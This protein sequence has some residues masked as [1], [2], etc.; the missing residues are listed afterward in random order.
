MSTLIPLASAEMPSKGGR[1]KGRALSELE[2]EHMRVLLG[3]RQLARQYMHDYEERLEDFA[4]RMRE[5]GC[6]T[7][8]MADALEIGHST[9]QGWITNAL[10]RRDGE[11]HLP[12]AGHDAPEE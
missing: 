5:T 2:L 10:R 7:R 1:P 12:K 4:L 6:S 11:T 8:V 9:V 3:V